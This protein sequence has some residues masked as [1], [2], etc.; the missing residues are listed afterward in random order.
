[1]RI[2]N[3]NPAIAPL[4]ERDPHRHFL[5]FYHDGTRYRL[6]RWC[7]IYDQTRRFMTTGFND[8]GSIDSKSFQLSDIECSGIRQ[9]L[10]QMHNKGQ[11]H[12]VQTP[13]GL[14]MFGYQCNDRNLWMPNYGTEILAC[15]TG[16]FNV[17]CA[18]IR[19]ND[20]LM[21]GSGNRY[22]MGSTRM[23]DLRRYYLNDTREE[24]E[25]RDDGFYLSPYAITDTQE[26]GEMEAPTYQLTTWGH[27]VFLSGLTRTLYWEVPRPKT[28]TRFAASNTYVVYFNSRS[29]YVYKMEGAKF[30][31]VCV[32]PHDKP[33]KDVKFSPDGQTLM[34]VCSSELVFYNTANWTQTKTLTMGSDPKHAL[35]F[36]AWSLDGLTCAAMSKETIQVWDHD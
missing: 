17:R 24:D 16:E 15:V 8:D 10:I 1:M 20:P 32:K 27:P 23:S 12:F 35:K 14:V 28:A 26:C 6:V 21:G 3:V 18:Y 31:R 5:G 11:Y 4:V 22:S 7:S 19:D 9:A 13:K 29:F 36:G 34:A 25:V 33:L 2:F 30:V